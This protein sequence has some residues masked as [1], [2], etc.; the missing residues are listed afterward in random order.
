M[1]L[2]GVAII[3]GK[4]KKRNSYHRRTCPKSENMERYKRAHIRRKELRKDISDKKRAKN[5]AWQPYVTSHKQKRA[6]DE[7]GGETARARRV[8][9]KEREKGNSRR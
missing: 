6:N 8:E 5:E 9:D 1:I 2:T 7:Y 4:D 3:A